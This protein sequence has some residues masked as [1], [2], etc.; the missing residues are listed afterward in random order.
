[1]AMRYRGQEE[2]IVVG[3]NTKVLD[4]RKMIGVRM[5]GDVHVH[6][7]W[8]SVAWSP[9]CYSS[10]CALIIFVFVTLHPAEKHSIKGARPRQT[11]VPGQGACWGRF[12]VY[13]R[14]HHDEA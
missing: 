6:E 13:V 10:W 14:Y 4:V 7:D 12:V 8:P 9:S 1:V 2:K 5:G 3:V 11:D